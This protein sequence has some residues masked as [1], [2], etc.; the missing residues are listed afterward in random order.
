MLNMFRV[1]SHWISHH[2]VGLPRAGLAIGE[3]AGVVALKRRLQ[4]VRAQIFENLQIKREIR[5]FI[6]AQTSLRLLLTNR[7]M[8]LQNTSLTWLR[9][10][11]LI[12]QSCNVICQ[13]SWQARVV[14]ESW[15]NTQSLSATSRLDREQEFDKSSALRPQIQTF[16]TTNHPKITTGDL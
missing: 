3:D 6:S 16:V 15:V 9:V 14:L 8:R 1:L 2:G 4:H 13:S 7:C 10:S 11:V 5:A 12:L